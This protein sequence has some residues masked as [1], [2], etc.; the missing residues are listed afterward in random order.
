[1]KKSYKIFLQFN[2]KGK[3]DSDGKISDGHISIKDQKACEKVWDKFNVKNLGDYHDHYLK[4]NVLLLTD[5]FQRFIT[6]CLKY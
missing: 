5:V 2:K 1:M 3:I 4:K 6:T